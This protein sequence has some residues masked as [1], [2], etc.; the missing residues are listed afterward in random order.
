MEGRPTSLREELGVDP[1]EAVFIHHPAGTLLWGITSLPSFFLFLPL[2]TNGNIW[3]QML[4][5]VFEAPVEDLQLF[6][7]EV[8]Q[9]DKV[10]QGLRFAGRQGQFSIGISSISCKRHTS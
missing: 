6:P 8:R 7:A 10:V 2:Y 5:D 4:P 3:G 9:L 1:L